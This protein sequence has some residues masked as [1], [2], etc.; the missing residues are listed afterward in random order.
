MINHRGPTR[1]ES[2]VTKIRAGLEKD[3]NVFYVFYGF[4]LFIFHCYCNMSELRFSFAYRPPRMICNIQYI[5]LKN[6]PLLILY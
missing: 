3:L 4:V 6:F 2:A 1:N 5:V